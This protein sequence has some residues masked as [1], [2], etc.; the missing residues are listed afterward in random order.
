MNTVPIEIRRLEG[1]AI[2][3]RWSDGL[4]AEIPGEAL[5]RGCPCASCRE[6]RGDT[7]HAKPLTTPAKPKKPLGLAI[8]DSSIAEQTA[9]TQIWPIGRYA[10]GMAWQDG[11][12]SGIY[13]Y[14]TLREFSERFQ[15][16]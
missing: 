2:A 11:H 4:F 14:E 3:I 7:S 8:V 6:L 15:G 1:A 16:R 5:R 9:L 13:T 12:D 10:I